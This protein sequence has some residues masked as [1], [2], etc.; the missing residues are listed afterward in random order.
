MSTLKLDIAKTI[1]HAH[2]NASY[3]NATNLKNNTVGSNA[4]NKIGE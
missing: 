1:H 3:H 4:K 2:N